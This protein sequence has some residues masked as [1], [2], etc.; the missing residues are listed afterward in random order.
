MSITR[1]V[2]TPEGFVDAEDQVHQL[3]QQPPQQPQWEAARV[4]T[5]TV[6]QQV[7]GSGSEDLGVTRHAATTDGVQGGSVLSTL[8]TEGPRRS[9]ELVPG[10][11][12]S[13]TDVQTALREGLLCVNA[14]GQ[15]EDA[16]NQQQLVQRSQE[17][18]KQE[19]TLGDP[20][21]EA[22][23]PQADADYAALIEPIPQGAYDAA[24][25]RMTGHLAHGS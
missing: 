15:L 6:R 9:V 14:A 18:P 24:A 7:G 19:S 3:K 17:T 4:Y 16:S 5:G 10:L 23:T 20:G 2:S 11:P 25:A 13:R 21:R 1:V 22:F 8:R 12:A